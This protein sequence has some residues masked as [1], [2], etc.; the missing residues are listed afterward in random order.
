MNGEQLNQFLISTEK[1]GIGPN[2]PNYVSF[3]LQYGDRNKKVSQNEKREKA[4]WGKNYARLEI[5]G[6]R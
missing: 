4:E 6:D 3:K 2:F 5:E 1:V